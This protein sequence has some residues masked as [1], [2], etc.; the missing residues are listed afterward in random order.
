ML[1]SRVTNS[2]L[3]LVP[4]PEGR[5]PSQRFR[6]EQYFNALEKAS[7]EYQVSSFLDHKVMSVLYDEGHTLIKVLAVAKGIIRRTADIFRAIRYDIVFIHRETTPIGP[8]LFEWILAKILK[9]KIIY[10]FD[11][12]IWISNSSSSNSSLT[13]FKWNTKVKWICR[14]SWKVSCGNKYLQQ[15][16]LR[17]NQ[18]AF[19][20]PTTIDTQF[21]HNRLKSHQQSV[22]TIGWTGTHSTIR[23]LAILENLFQRLEKEYEFILL[24]IGDKRPTLNLGSLRFVPWSKK[25]EIEDL[26]KID[27]GIMPLRNDAWAKGKCGFKAL[28]YM[29]LGIPAIVSDVGVNSEIVDHNIDGWVCRTEEEWEII[30]RNLLDRKIDLASYSLAA[31]RKIELKYS[32]TSNTPNFLHLFANEKVD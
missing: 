8:P 14:W 3:F 11:D 15:F 29:A 21:L 1:K 6:F 16:A 7:Y 24:V 27:V 30:L 20:N 17:V 5:A 25:T 31:R 26:L 32:V 9:K 22:F 13:P 18:H 28:Q 23:Y 12:A 19:I 4:Y 2:I 10:D